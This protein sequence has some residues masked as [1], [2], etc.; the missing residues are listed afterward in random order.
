[1]EIAL[2]KF[3]LLYLIS[4]ISLFGYEYD[5]L[6]M[7][8]EAKL[9]PK[10]AL[11]EKN[12]QNK[13]DTSLDIV[14]IAKEVDIS[15]AKLFQKKITK[16]YPSALLGRKIIPS[17]IL[18]SKYKKLTK[19][20]DVIIVLAYRPKEMQSISKWANQHKIVSFVYDPKDLQYGFLGSVFIGLSVKPYLNK[21]IIKEY[22]FEFEPYLLQLSKF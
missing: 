13:T 16:R 11:M 7:D 10:I 21:S 8:I 14:I 6:I 18:F 4:I 5:P 22:G 15:Y 20:P 1:M 19:L 2:K 12:I 3:F 17:V 9:F